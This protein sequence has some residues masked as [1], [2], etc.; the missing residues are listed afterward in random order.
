MKRDT[1][2]MKLRGT[3]TS[4]HTPPSTLHLAPRHPIPLAANP[5]MAAWQPAG[6]SASFFAKCLDQARNDLR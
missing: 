6:R 2:A 3:A 4:L 1:I 5:Y